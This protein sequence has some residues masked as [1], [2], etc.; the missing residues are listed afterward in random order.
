[1]GYEEKGN[2]PVANGMTILIVIM[3]MLMP[4]WCGHIVDIKGAFLH[5]DFEDGEEN[6]MEVPQDLKVT[7]HHGL[8]C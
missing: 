1:M 3:L 7:I 4:G 8:Y 2:A 5:E 6:Y